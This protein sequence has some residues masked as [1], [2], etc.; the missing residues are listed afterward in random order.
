MFKYLRLGPA[1]GKAAH[2]LF[3]LVLLY[4]GTA[5][6]THV[7]DTAYSKAAHFLACIALYWDSNSHACA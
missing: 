5:I 3:L 2:F 1:Y 4:A 7:P 6:A